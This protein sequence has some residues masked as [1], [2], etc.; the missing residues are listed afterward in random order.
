[1]SRVIS[2]SVKRILDRI[3]SRPELSLSL[4]ILILV[5]VFGVLSPVFINVTNFLVLT[6]QMAI[7]TCLAIGVSFV[8]MA[9]EMDLSFASTME[10]VGAVTVTLSYSYGLDWTICLSVGFLTAIVIA[11]SNAFLVVKLRIPSFLATL[12]LFILLQGGAFWL[13]R[14]AY[15]P[16]SNPV[17]I[18]IFGGDIF[19]FPRITIWMAISIAI[20]CAIL[21]KLRFGTRLLLTGGN[22][23]AAKLEGINTNYIKTSAFVLSALF[24]FLG[25]LLMLGKTS[26][27]SPEMGQGYLL[28][29]IAAP[30]IGGTLL[31]GGKGSVIGTVLGAL[32]LT[33]LINGLTLIGVEPGGLLVAQGLVVIAGLALQNLRSKRL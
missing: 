29:A 21:H 25:A 4:F 6:R 3:I 14:G 1:M 32:L 22:S 20:A 30:I 15:V 24:A 11:L 13:V 12:A 2:Q 9:G 17:L 7:L 5:I 31:S 33:L 26:H 8:I 19:G 10:F 23:Q 28:Q 16:L 27:Y 18:A